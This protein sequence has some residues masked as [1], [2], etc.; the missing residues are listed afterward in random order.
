M[1][2][3]NLIHFFF[4]NFQPLLTEVAAAAPIDPICKNLNVLI[5]VA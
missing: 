3:Q 1:I 2:F 5:D 4:L